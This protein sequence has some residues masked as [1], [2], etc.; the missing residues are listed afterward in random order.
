MSNKSKNLT[1]TAI[2]DAQS[3]SITAFFNEIP[4]LLVQGS[5]DDDVKKKLGS[6][7]E[8]YIRRLDSVKHNFDLQ[9]KSI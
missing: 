1:A 2:V 5:S 7:L 6:L 4:G 3:G 9:V 8:S